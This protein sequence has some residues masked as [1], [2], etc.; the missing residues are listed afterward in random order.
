V[1]LKLVTNLLLAICAG[2]MATLAVAS[3]VERAQAGREAA[4]LVGQATH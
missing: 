1:T 4:A 2:G 3:G